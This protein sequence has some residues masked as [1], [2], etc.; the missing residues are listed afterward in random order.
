MWFMEDTDGISGEK[1]IEKTND[2]NTLLKRFRKQEAQTKGERH[3]NGRLKHR[4]Y[5]AFCSEHDCSG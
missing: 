3:E 2:L 4:H 1:K 5:S